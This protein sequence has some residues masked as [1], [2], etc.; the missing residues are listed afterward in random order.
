MFVKRYSFNTSAAIKR[1]DEIRIPLHITLNQGLV[2]EPELFPPLS[3]TTRNIDFKTS[4]LLK[5]NLTSYI[6]KYSDFTSTDAKGMTSSSDESAE[7]SEAETVKHDSK[8]AISTTS[9]EVIQEIRTERWKAL[10]ADDKV[11]SKKSFFPTPVLCRTCNELDQQSKTHK[12]S[13]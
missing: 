10:K 4:K 13:L 2:S 11:A 9:K 6:E 5:I 1:D 8:F 3:P 12:G 7:S